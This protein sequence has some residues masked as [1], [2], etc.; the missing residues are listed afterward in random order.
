MPRAYF[1]AGVFLIIATLRCLALLFYEGE[2]VDSRFA[3]ARLVIVSLL[4]LWL[5]FDYQQSLVNLARLQR[6]DGERIAA[7]ETAINSGAEI[8]VVPQFRPEFANRYSSLHRHD[9]TEDPDYWVNQFYKKYYGIKVCAIPR[10]EWEEI[11]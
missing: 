6:E 4:W 9:M 5:F 7:I 2:T 1:G 3:A 11:Y 8:A 10:E